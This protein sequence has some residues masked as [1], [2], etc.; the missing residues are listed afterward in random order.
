MR[1]VTISL[2]LYCE[3]FSVPQVYRLYVNDDLLTERNYIWQNPEQ[4]VREHIVV[5]LEPGTHEI[6]IEPVSDG[7]R[8]FSYKNVHLD[9]KLIGTVNNRFVLV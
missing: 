1:E 8:G 6:R 2:D 9:K 5:N 3:P 4:F 7:F